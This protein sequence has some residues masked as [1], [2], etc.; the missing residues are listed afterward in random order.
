VVSSLERKR[1]SSDGFVSL[2]FGSGDE[3]AVLVSGLGATPVMEQYIFYNRVAEVLTE[4]GITVHRPY[5]GNYFT[6]LEMMG[7]TL[8]VMKLDAE[9][10]ELID[11]D[12]YS[13]GLRQKRMG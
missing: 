1:Q 4:K 9:L 8:T 13:M 10:K 11:M 5:V 3:V 12:A 7:I 6:S 2:P